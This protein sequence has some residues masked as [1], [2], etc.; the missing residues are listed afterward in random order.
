MSHT[1]PS[2]PHALPP[3]PPNPPATQPRCGTFYVPWN[4]TQQGVPGDTRCSF[5]ADTGCRTFRTSNTGMWAWSVFKPVEDCT[6]GDSPWPAAAAAASGASAALP[7][8]LCAAWDPAPPP[9]ASQPCPAD[10]CPSPPPAPPSPTPP[11]PTPP[12]AAPSPPPSPPQPPPS[13]R[14]SPAPP[15]FCTTSDTAALLSQLN[16]GAADCDPTAPFPACGEGELCVA[17]VG[18][19]QWGCDAAAAAQGS[20][21]QRPCVGL[22]RPLA[23]GPLAARLTPDGRAVRLSLSAPAAPLAAVAAAGGS[24][25]SAASGVGCDQV[26]AADTAALLGGA[27]AVCWLEA[28]SSSGSSGSSGSST[29]GSSG[30][31][32]VARLAANSMALVGAGAQRGG[33]ST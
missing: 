2:Y 25:A 33:A 23:L 26:F 29:S 14:A 15:P 20:L 22:C 5:N 28:D 21:T 11:S 9:A 16:W 6:A 19:S 24:A 7:L 27:G 12:A 8:S 32:L 10:A 1:L 13:P 4:L 31:V 3:S 30:R 17:V 18:C